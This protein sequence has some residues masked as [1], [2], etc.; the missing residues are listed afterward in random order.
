MNRRNFTQ[1]LLASVAADLLFA[2]APAAA[3]QPA[4]V[5][6][7]TF[8]RLQT[9]QP[10][11]SPGKVEV[12]EFFSYACPHCNA[13]EPDLEAWARM[14]PGDVVLRRV[15][16]PFLANAE[17]FQRTYFALDALGLV[18]TM[19]SKIFAAVHVERRN[20]GKPDDIAAVIERN[21][22]D[23]ARFLAAFQSFSVATAV[24]RA[25]KMTSDF[26]IDT[27]PGV[28][29]LVVQGSYLTSPAHAGGGRQALAVVDALVQRARKG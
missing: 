25:K 11:Q 14:L 18:T 12:I 6:G 10:T 9:P 5:E 24:N 1:A 13:F 20:L 21:G 29:A 28:P 22:G 3:Q 2:A 7:R 27:G 19:Q 26:G 23:A 17:N 8:E 4:L 15:P 16:V